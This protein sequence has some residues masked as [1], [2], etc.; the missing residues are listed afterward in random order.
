[1]SLTDSLIP[2]GTLPLADPYLLS[3]PTT[4]VTCNNIHRAYTVDGVRGAGRVRESSIVGSS[5]HRKDVHA[6][7][8]HVTTSIPL[9]LPPPNR[10]SR[11]PPIDTDVPPSAV[12][13]RPP[14]GTEVR[15]D[16]RIA[17]AVSGSAGI[18]VALL[19]P[20]RASRLMKWHGGAHAMA[21]S[22][23]ACTWDDFL[24]CQVMGPPTMLPRGEL[25][26]ASVPTSVVT[27]P[28]VLPST[29]S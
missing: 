1:M 26:T 18:E 10:I 22:C 27:R 25:T 29:V 2:D 6:L 11:P 24:D 16:P 12:A 5:A 15:G 13:S 3:P 9:S 8:R 28:C 23:R 14:P 19:Q 17:S 20:G 21:M 4:H 7:R